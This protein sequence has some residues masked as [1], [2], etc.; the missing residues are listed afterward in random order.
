VDEIERF[1]TGQPLLYQIHQAN[2]E[3]IA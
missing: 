1:V 2:L 3:N